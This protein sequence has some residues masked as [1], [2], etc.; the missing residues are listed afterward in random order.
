MDV[1]Q[2]HVKR[3]RAYNQLDLSKVSHQCDERSREEPRPAAPKAL[4]VA[5]R[6]HPS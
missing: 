1:A 6:I 4:A 5:R 2:Q 3:N